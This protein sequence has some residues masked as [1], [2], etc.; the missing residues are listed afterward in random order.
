[1]TV[2]KPIRS[3]NSYFGLAKEVVAGTPVAP[4]WFPRWMDGSS[5]EYD[6]KTEEVWE[7]DG[8]RRMSQ[9]VKNQQSIKIKL[10]VS[11]RMN[12]LG[13]LEE[14]C[15]GSGSDTITPGTPAGTLHLATTGGT[16]TTL[17]V[18]DA[19]LSSLIT[20]AAG[21]FYLL[22]VDPTA[23]NE[24]VP[25][26]LPATGAGPYVFTVAS[27]YNSGHV[28]LTH[29][30][31]DALVVA[32]LTNVSTSLTAAVLKGAT[33][34]PLGNDLNLTTASSTQVLILSPG[35]S[36]EEIVTVTT[37][38]TSG[39][40]PWVYTLANS[41]TCKNAHAS[42]DLVFSPVTHVLTDQSD[43][44]YF[45]IEVGLG[46]LNG[47]AG[48][49]LRV[50]SCKC[51]SRKIS[52]K[53]GGLLMYELEF[54]GIASSVQNTPATISLEQHPLFLYTQGV[55]TLDSS[56]GGDALNIPSWDIEQKNN[57]APVQTEALTNAAIIFGNVTVALGFEITYTTANRI[58]LVYFGG[59]SGTTD[60]QAIGAGAWS[61]TFTQPDTFE[62]VTYSMLTTH[63]SKIGL[64]VPKKDG[65][66]FRQAISAA[67]VSNSG[68]NPYVLQTTVTNS[69]L[70]NY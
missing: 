62:S 50:R 59:S 33:T 37:P 11:P 24:V 35:L 16:S 28:A 67:S 15:M 38:A 13:F 53:A 54:T 55:W 68:A 46:S 20:P 19:G 14:A 60:A 40:G 22:I 43:G 2:I 3:D 4:S 7:G 41:A 66:E 44:D 5:I 63:Y 56:T 57:L 36:T 30:G 25:C 21:T 65:K 26:T 10:T 39:T 32:P 42:G 34:I 49:T 45:T 61:V 58:Y 23:G 48:T 29:A 9:L 8:T 31:S 1:M 51:E 69:Q 12:E 6:L 64:P 47:A 52:G 27:S 70:S 17:S 18:T